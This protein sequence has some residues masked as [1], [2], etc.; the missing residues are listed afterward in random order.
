MKCELCNCECELTA[1]H[2]IPKSRIR[3]KYK[4]MKEDPSNL[5]WICRQ[6]HDQIHAL[7]DESTLRDLYST[8]DKLLADEKMQ[9][10][11]AWRQK[12]PDFDGHSKMSNSRKHR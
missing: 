3:N 12:H 6:C 11:I 4:E 8:K 2:L 1:H 5:I 9:K 7:W 10:F